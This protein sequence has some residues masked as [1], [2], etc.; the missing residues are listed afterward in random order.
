MIIST[1][2]GMGKSTLSKDRPNTIDLESSC[3][4][5]SNGN[6]YIDYCRVAMDLDRQGYT[7][8][9]SAHKPVRDY[10]R[11]MEFLDYHMI[12]YSPSLKDYA[13]G[14]VT[15]RYEKSRT[16]KDWAAFKKAHSSFDAI[17]E[18][19]KEDEKDGLSVIWVRSP[20]YKLRTIVDRLERRAKAKEESK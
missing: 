5:K 8:L 14:K 1:F 6:W 11:K 7:V 16:L 10:L 3:F 18:E 13:I 4:D 12:M 19:I 17:V 20:E 15:E 2:Q 9:V